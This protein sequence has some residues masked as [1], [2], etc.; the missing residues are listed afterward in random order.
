MCFNTQ[1]YEYVN[2][3]FRPSAHFHVSGR[4]AVVC[5]LK[6]EPFFLPNYISS[7]HSVRPDDLSYICEISV[8]AGYCCEAENK[9][10]AY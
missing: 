5:C 3:R 10:I 4:T 1:Q 7:T 2:R 8:V 6:I 9:S